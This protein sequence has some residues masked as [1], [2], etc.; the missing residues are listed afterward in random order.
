VEWVAWVVWEEWV[1]WECNA[2]YS[3]IKI[4]KGQFL[5]PFFFNINFF[6]KL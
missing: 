1:A 4:L 3:Q 2:N 6:Y 5:L